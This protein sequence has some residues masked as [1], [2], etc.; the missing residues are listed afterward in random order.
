MI[1]SILLYLK[2]V[3]PQDSEI[4]QRLKIF[5]SLLAVD[6]KLEKIVRNSG[7]EVPQETKVCL[8]RLMLLLVVNCTGHQGQHIRPRSQSST[9]G[10]Y[11]SVQRW[12]GQEVC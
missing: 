5:I 9:L 11:I 12:C 1:P 8:L 3:Y 10:R 4:G 6:K 2:R 7:F